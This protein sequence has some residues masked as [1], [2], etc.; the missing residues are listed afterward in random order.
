MRHTLRAVARN[1]IPAALGVLFAA[2]P[3]RAQVAAVTDLKNDVAAFEV[4]NPSAQTM[5]V[6]VAL[7]HGSIVDGNLVLGEA[8]DAIVG[9]TAFRLL[10]G[11]SQTVRALVREPVEPG[12]V[13]RIVTTL[14]PVVEQ[15]DG[16]GR[17]RGQI[18]LATRLIT[19]LIVH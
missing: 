1:A 13:L 5:S 11:G 4:R 6:E 15:Q 2:V 14:T 7:H 10:P 16:D 8:V 18:V 9:P 19:K 17:P 12:R 3:A